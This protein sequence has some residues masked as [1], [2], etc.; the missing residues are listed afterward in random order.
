MLL[1][2]LTPIT[3]ADKGVN[4]TGFYSDFTSAD[5]TILA[6]ED[7]NATLKV[8]LLFE[9]DPEKVELSKTVNMALNKGENYKVVVW[10]Q[11]PRFDYYTARARLFVNGKLVDE[12]KHSFSYGT[13]ALPDF[14]IVDFTPNNK[15]IYLLLRPFRPTVADITFE[16]LEGEDVVYAENNTN[17]PLITTKEFRIPWPFLLEK[18]QVYTVR[19]KVFTHRLNSASIQNTYVSSFTAT[20]DVEIMQEDVDVDEVGASIT[21]LGKSQVPFD[22][23]VNITL[24]KDDGREYQFSEVTEILLNTQEDTIG[25]VWDLPSG[26]YTAKI[27]VINYEGEVKDTYE[28]AFRVPERPRVAVTETPKTPGFSILPTLAAMLLT[29]ILCRR[30]E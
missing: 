10:E 28:T 29:M 4:I 14:H 27:A 11:K 8:D 6:E 15:E 24:I 19:L 20:D 12:K 16:V 7:A 5:I 25:V 2:S 18:H 26:V 3:N 13:A 30:R 21:I 1:S 9:D 22:G 17:I 23:Y